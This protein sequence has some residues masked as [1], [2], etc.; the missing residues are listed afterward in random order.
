MAKKPS[1]GKALDWTSELL[2]RRILESLEMAKIELEKA[3]IADK[4]GKPLPKKFIRTKVKTYSKRVSSLTTRI[5]KLKRGLG[6]VILTNPEFYKKTG[7]FK[8]I[9][10]RIGNPEEW[11][12][13]LSEELTNALG[14]YG[15]KIADTKSVNEFNPAGKV[16]HHR[17]A[18]SILRDAIEPLDVDVRAEFKKLALADGYKVGE[19]FIDYLDP[20]AHKRMNST[21]QGI[22]AKK[23]IKPSEKLLSALTERSAHAAAFGSEAG[24]IL[25]KQLIKKGANA[26]EVYKYARPYLE[27]ARRGSE[28]GLQLDEIITSNRWNTPQELLEIVEKEMPIQDTTPILNRMRK[29]LIDTGLYTDKGYRGEEIE[30]AV[31]KEGG[32]QFAGGRSLVQDA[33]RSGISPE[34]MKKPGAIWYAPGEEVPLEAIE[35]AKAIGARSRKANIFKNVDI[36]SLAKVSTKLNNADSL[37]QIAGGNYLGGSIGLVMNSNAF[38]KAIAKRFAQANLKLIPGVGIGMSG[39][40]SAGYAS[41]GR[42]TQAGIAALSGAVGELGP[43]GDVFSGMLDIGNTTID[44]FTGNLKPGLEVDED[45]LGYLSRQVRKAA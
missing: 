3:K 16:G 11:T 23:N 29:D 33:G 7:L 30:F 26:D 34:M 37:A 28:S 39:L 36:A 4:Q 19:E 22:L 42:F 8:M 45:D 12:E 38:R 2:E 5:K 17:T 18:L 25:P 27:L 13:L 41:Q 20:A 31:S 43:L 9:G 10:E 21:L 14:S 32:R 40:E 44:A 15:G 24:L 1:I 35:N 6:G